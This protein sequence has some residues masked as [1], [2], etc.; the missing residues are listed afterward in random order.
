[1]ASGSRGVGSD[2]VLLTA[3]AS[4]KGTAGQVLSVLVVQ[5]SAAGRVT[6]RDGGSGGAIKWQC[7]TVALGSSIPC[8]LGGSFGLEFDTDIFCEIAGAGTKASVVFI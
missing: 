1:M 3:S 6:L 7:D 8:A 5:G 4:V 2:G